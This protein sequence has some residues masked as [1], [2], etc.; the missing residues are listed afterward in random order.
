MINSSEAIVQ[1]VI[2]VAH[3]GQVFRT[4]ATNSDSRELFDCICRGEIQLNYGLLWNTVDY[5]IN[6]YANINHHTTA[7]VIT[8]TAGRSFIMYVFIGLK[9]SYSDLQFSTATQIHH[10][11]S[12]CVP[13]II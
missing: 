10:I 5:A 4:C 12:T 1:N 2:I 3:S 8:I 13:N 9:F 6:M 11:N 7:T